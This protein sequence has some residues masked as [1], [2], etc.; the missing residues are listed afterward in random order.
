MLRSTSVVEAAEEAELTRQTIHRYLKDEAFRAEL[1]RLQDEILARTTAALVGLAEEAVGVLR[2]VM[3]DEFA[4]DSVRVRA[5]HYALKYELD[6][7]E[8][9][10]LS[11]RVRRLEEEVA[12]ER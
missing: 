7:L 11:E 2:D 10:S 3:H 1:R 5:A 9:M 8:L 12:G 6:M 4:S